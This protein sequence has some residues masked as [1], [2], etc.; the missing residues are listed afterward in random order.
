MKKNKLPQIKRRFSRIA[1]FLK[2]ECAGGTGL[3]RKRLCN[4]AVYRDFV[5]MPRTETL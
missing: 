1:L 3:M 2:K 4:N 5:T